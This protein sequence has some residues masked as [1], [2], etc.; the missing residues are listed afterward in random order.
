MTLCHPL[1]GFKGWW[2]PYLGF[3]SYLASPQATICRPS[4]AISLAACI[5]QLAIR[6]ILYCHRIFLLR[7]LRAFVVKI[8]FWLRLCSDRLSCC[9]PSGQQAQPRTYDNVLAAPIPSILCG[10]LGPQSTKT[11]GKRQ[12]LVGNPYFRHERQTRQDRFIPMYPQTEWTLM[13]TTKVQFRK[14]GC[15]CI[16]TYRHQTCRLSTFVGGVNF[17]CFT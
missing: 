4:G 15:C 10:C 13:P 16:R 9:A 7:G 8:F 11:L 17:H 5:T 14:N 2:S 3:R 1:R 6:S 12:G